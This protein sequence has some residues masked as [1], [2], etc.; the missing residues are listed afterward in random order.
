MTDYIMESIK[1]PLEEYINDVAWWM[2]STQGIFTVKSA[3]E[4]MKHKQERRAD[5]QLIWTKEVPFKMIF[6]LWRLWK[7]RIATDDNLKS[8][9]MESMHLQQLIINWWKHSYNAKLEVVMRAMPTIIMW[10]LWKRR[11]NLKHGGTT[12]YNE[13]VMQVQKEV[14]KLI[15][16]QHPWIHI[17]KETWPQIITKLKEYRPKIHHHYVQWK[18]PGRN[19]VKCNTDGQ[20]EEIQVLVL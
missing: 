7:R 13:M 10:T 3:W 8:M 9:Q 11:N 1:P 14:R 15:K 5:Y 6:F 16:L 18:K 12:T 19:T 2:G 17:K 20:Q 4:L